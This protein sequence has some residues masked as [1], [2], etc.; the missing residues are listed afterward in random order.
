MVEMSEMGIEPDAITYKTAIRARGRGCPLE[1]GLELLAALRQRGLEPNLRVAGDLLQATHVGRVSELL[2]VLRER[3]F[4]VDVFL[5]NAAMMACLNGSL[6]QEALAL[7]DEMYEKE[8]RQD[9]LSYSL[10]LRAC[11]ACNEPFKASELLAVMQ[12]EGVEIDAAA[13]D[14]AI[15]LFAGNSKA[16]ELLHEICGPGPLFEIASDAARTSAGAE[17]SRH[18]RLSALPTDARA[19]ATQP[20]ATADGGAAHRAKGEDAQAETTRGLEPAAITLPKPMRVKI[21][22]AK[23][24]WA[25]TDFDRLRHVDRLWIVFWIAAA[26]ASVCAGETTT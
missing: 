4:A 9:A 24:S 14:A 17:L 7:V 20:A 5:Y 8:I 3:G 11:E 13:Y 1:K 26:I 15:R 18:R 19:R 10:A 2:W 6:P 23:A 25:S 16:L 22:R 21:S 12:K